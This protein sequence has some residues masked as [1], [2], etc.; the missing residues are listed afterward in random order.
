MRTQKI[1]RTSL[2]LAT[3]ALLAH[4]LPASTALHLLPASSSDRFDYALG[5]GIGGLVA[6]HSHD[7]EN[8]LP[9]TW[10][11]VEAGFGGPSPLPLPVSVAG[12]EVSWVAGDGAFIGGFAFQPVAGR[13]D[14]NTVPVLWT[15]GPGGA[16]AATILPRVGGSVSESA[17]FGG[18]V[19]ATRLVGQSGATPAAVLWR[20][21]PLTGYVVQNLLLPSGASGPSSALAAS[22]DGARLVGRYETTAGGQS[23]LWTESGA[24]YSP[25]RLAAPAGGSQTFVETISADGAL[26]A[27]AA[28]TAAGLRPVRWDA[29]TGSVSQ[30][31]TLGGLEATV[32]AIA[33]N[34]AW[35]GGRATDPGSFAGV[36]VLWDRDG[37]IHEVAT[38]AAAAGAAFSDFWPESV[39]AI[40]LVS[41]GVYTITGTGVGATSG[42]TRG[43]VLE[44]L[45]LATAL[46][47][48]PPG[49]ELPPSPPPTT[50]PPAPEPD[51]E[52]DADTIT[53]PSTPSGVFLNRQ[54]SSQ[55]PAKF[56]EPASAPKILGGG[57]RDK[58]R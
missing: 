31:D 5:R 41:S 52:G 36:A 33:D 40:H 11:K 22:A 16:Y 56:A 47:P 42:A 6:G 21:A 26:A 35:L 20:G 43:Y 14:I 53:V 28:E 45:A 8:V 37:R 4:A 9:V 34:H 3:L 46:P 39:T 49:P 12:G 13:D 19:S 48:L 50:N 24:A 58:D 18:D 32:L 29:G 51:P 10:Q 55:S 2:P 38:L 23:V 54:R 25:V 15:R 30:L 7:F 17:I 44:N 27:G 57:R 1:L